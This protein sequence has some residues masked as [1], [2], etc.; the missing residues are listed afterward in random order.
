MSGSAEPE[1]H[2]RGRKRTKRLPSLGWR[3]WV[4]LPGLGVG[5]IKAKVDTGARSAALHAFEIERFERAGEI[6]VRFR[7]HP[8]QRSARPTVE[9][10]G[11]L[12]DERWVRS[13]SG[14]ATLRPV[15]RTPL[16][17]GKRRWLIEVSLVRR[18]LMG[19]RLLLGRQS[20][21]NRFVVDPGKSFLAGPPPAL[22]VEA[23]QP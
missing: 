14:R 20:V 1:R 2:R 13:S 6:W 4:G 5:Q 11:Q 18:D 9:A 12:I 17:V 19:F 15:I 10:E 3:E 7:V 21:R 16:V 8:V 22:N 23:T